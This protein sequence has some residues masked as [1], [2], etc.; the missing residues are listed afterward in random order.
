[1]AYPRVP[2]TSFLTMQEIERAVLLY[3]SAVP[4]TFA[5]RCRDEIIAPILPRINEALGQE[6]DALYLAYAVEYVLAEVS[7]ERKYGRKMEEGS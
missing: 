6:N 4:G 7:V 5:A 2:I 1:M 3:Q